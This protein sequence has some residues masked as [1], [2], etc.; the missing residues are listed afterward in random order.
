MVNHAKLQSFMGQFV[1][2]LGAVL[3][4]P[5]VPAGAEPGHHGPLA[6]AG[7]QTA[8]DLAARV[9][10]EPR[11]VREWLCANAAAGHVSYELTTG[12]REV[13]LVLEARP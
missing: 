13:I 11:Y 7:P 5:L 10:A 9:E 2:D 3:H 12:L 6:D 4:A 8:A 1:S